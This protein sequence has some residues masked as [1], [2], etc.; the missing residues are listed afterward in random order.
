MN[1]T[2]SAPEPESTAADRL[3]ERVRQVNAQSQT[4]RL[5]KNGGDPK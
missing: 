4:N 5:S 3:R 1:N 2:P